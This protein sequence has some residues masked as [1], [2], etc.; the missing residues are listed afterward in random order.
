VV[1]GNALGFDPTGDGHRDSERYRLISVAFA[2][3]TS[4]LP[5]FVRTLDEFGMVL[6]AHCR[7]S[8]DGPSPDEPHT[9]PS[10]RQRPLG[11]GRGLKQLIERPRHG[12][13]DDG[14]CPV[15]D[16][17]YGLTAWS[18]EHP[19]DTDKGDRNRQRRD[20]KT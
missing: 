3:R 16:A 14:E 19:R 17:A 12:R 11:S 20:A 4:D 8:L 13:S 10:L 15:D 5:P 1:S 2:L 7:F 18:A 6:L 9:N